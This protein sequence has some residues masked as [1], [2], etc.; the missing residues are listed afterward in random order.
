MLDLVLRGAS[1]FSGGSSG[2]ISLLISGSISLRISGSISLLVSGIVSELSRCGAISGIIATVSESF[3]F[4]FE[5]DLLF[6]E[7]FLL[8]SELFFEE[9]LLF[10]EDPLFLL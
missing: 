10:D 8:F 9:D 5:D 2:S 3:C 1:L 6:F 7:E 4:F